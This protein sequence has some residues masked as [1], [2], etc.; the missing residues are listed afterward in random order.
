MARLGLGE[1]DRRDPEGAVGQLGREQLERRRRLAARAPRVAVGGE[2][3][4]GV[5]L[6]HLAAEPRE[7]LR[8]VEG[9]ER[10]GSIS[11][12]ELPL[13]ARR[14]GEQRDALRARLR[15]PAGAPGA[16]AS[17]RRRRAGR[18]S[19]PTEVPSWSW[20]LRLGLD[21]LL[22]GQLAQRARG[23]GGAMPSAPSST[24]ATRVAASGVWKWWVA[25]LWG[26]ARWKSPRAG[27][28]AEQRPDA[29]AARRLA[30]DR[31]VLG[32]AAEAPRCGSAPTR[33]RAT[34]SR[35]PGFET[36]PPKSGQSSARCRKPSAPS[37]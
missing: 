24:S 29:H 12:E 5:D 30:E 16:A 8:L 2:Q 15:A 34:W 1:A 6:G 7:E 35:I 32:V 4:V 21:Q 36:A 33:A 13:V 20:S 27:G 19:S 14:A 18:A 22:R 11:H 31:D 26:I 28:H 10:L 37:R 3:L 17:R 9:G 23:V 25:P